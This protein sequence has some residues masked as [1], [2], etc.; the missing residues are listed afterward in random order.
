[1]AYRPLDP[2]LDLGAV[3]AFRH[4][5]TVARDNTVRYRWRTLELL[6]GPERT[7]Y[8]GVQVEVVERPDGELSVQHQGITIP[9]R[10]APPRAGVLREARA[11]LA[12]SP[13]P[14]AHRLR[15]RLRGRTPATPRDACR[16]GGG[17]C[18]QRRRREARAREQAAP[19][20]YDPTARP[21]EGD[22]AGAATGALDA[23]N[24]QPARDLPRHRQ[25]LRPGQRCAWTPERRRGILRRRR[26]D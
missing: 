19:P 4:V 20:T 23:G 13:R 2:A 18:A 22:R 25:Q 7:S 1:M 9:S 17:G 8:A 5:R 6:P 11:G 21:L 14:R 12:P 15:A 10:P 24:R 16:P 26:R 3:L